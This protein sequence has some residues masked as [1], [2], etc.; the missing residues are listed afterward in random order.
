MLEACICVVDALRASQ[1][2]KHTLS[3]VTLNVTL[4]DTWPHLTSCAVKVTGFKDDISDDTVTLFFESAKR[5]G[6]G[7]VEEIV[8]DEQ[9]RSVVIVFESRDGLL[10]SLH[11]NHFVFVS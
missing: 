8:I 3:K 11:V 4:Q 6:G 7:T 2:A 10:T 9:E 5:S 1:Q